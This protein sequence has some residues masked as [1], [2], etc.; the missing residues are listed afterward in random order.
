MVTPLKGCLIETRL[1]ILVYTYI[2]IRYIDLIS[3]MRRHWWN[4]VSCFSPAIS[5]LK[6]KQ[7]YY[8]THVLLTTQFEASLFNRPFW[9]STI[10]VPYRKSH[11]MIPWSFSEK[12]RHSDLVYRGSYALIGIKDGTAI[13]EEAQLCRA[14]LCQSQSGFGVQVQ[15]TKWIYNQTIPS[16]TYRGHISQETWWLKFHNLYIYIYID[17]RWPAPPRK[18][19]EMYRVEHRI[20]QTCL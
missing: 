12:C 14:K 18:G 20:S 13:A 6:T 10:H 7:T 8:T 5:N 2:H 3:W 11:P 16:H 17:N 15:W 1:Y 4:P 9:Q 19:I